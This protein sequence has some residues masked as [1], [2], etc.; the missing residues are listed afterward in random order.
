MARDAG[1]TIGMPLRG[2]HRQRADLAGCNA[3]MAGCAASSRRNM[4]RMYADRCVAARHAVRLDGGCCR[5]LRHAAGSSPWRQ[6][7]GVPGEPSG[8]FRHP[9]APLAAQI[10]PCK[11]ANCRGTTAAFTVGC[12]PVG[13]AAM[14]LLASHHSALTMQFL[15]LASH[16]LHSG[17]LQTIPRGLALDFGSWLSLFTMSPSRYSHRGLSPRKFA[18]MLGAHL[19]FQPAAFGGC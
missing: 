10:S 4:R 5:L 15:S 7:L 14:C 18:P 9:L 16:L 3:E 12:A 8:S 19:L 6:V 1:W 17:F 13:F 11:N 2:V